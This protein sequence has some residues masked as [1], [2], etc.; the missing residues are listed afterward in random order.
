[1]K[2]FGTPSGAAPG[3][4]S[5]YVGFDGV[6]APPPLRSPVDLWCAGVGL[7][8][9]C[10]FL[11]LPCFFLPWCL[12]F[13]PF[14]A[15]RVD[16]FSEMPGVPAGGAWLLEV[17]L[18]LVVEDLELDDELEL[19]DEL[20]EEDDEELVVL[21]VVVVDP[22]P[23]EHTSL[24]ERTGRLAG[25]SEE[26][27]TPTGTLNTRP[28]TVV[29]WSTQLVAEPAG[30]HAPRP[31]TTVAASPTRS[32]GLLNRMASLLPRFDCS[33]PSSRDQRAR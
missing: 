33:Q 23:D 11:C 31:A 18:V 14:G 9:G 3:S 1:M 24:T 21:V 4:A 8:L 13:A 32:L 19:E 17:V 15:G 16:F 12:A 5:V 27:C 6:G 7:E 10:F 30:V 25:T 2:K 28:P 22:V 20:E 26:I 29:T